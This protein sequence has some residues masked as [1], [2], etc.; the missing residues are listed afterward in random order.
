M[1]GY[2]EIRGGR[3]KCD[4]CDHT[5]YKTYAGI[6]THL[7]THHAK[8]LNEVLANELAKT[9]ADLHKE[10][11][12]PPKVE[13]RE[14]VV[15]RD[16]PEPKY[17][18]TKNVGIAGIYCT[19]CKQVQLNVGIPVGQTIENSPHQCGNRTLLPVVEVR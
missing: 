5:S 17:W 4:F 7:Q 16:K 8:Q 3:Y 12:K 2:H 13:V 9:M 19:S 14:K 6:T 18:Y 11:I 15:Y 1:K 10:R